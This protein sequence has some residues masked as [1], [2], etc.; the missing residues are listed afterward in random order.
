VFALCSHGDKEFR[1]VKCISVSDVSSTARSLNSIRDVPRLNLVRRQIIPIRN[2][3]D[4]GP[5]APRGGG[6]GG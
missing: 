5:P 1:K 4:S 2:F 6:G 3:H